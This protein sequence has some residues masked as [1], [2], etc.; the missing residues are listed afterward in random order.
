MPIRFFLEPD[1]AF[2]PNEV[3]ILVNAFEDT[4]RALNL[5]NREDPLTTR[6][7]KVIIGLAKDGERDPARLRNRI[8]CAVNC[9][10][11]GPSAGLFDP[12]SASARHCFSY[13]G[14]GAR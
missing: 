8:L 10:E 7:A 3:K 12:W 13:P 2:S 4:L 6:V 11:L 5:T 1:H 14:E 9:G